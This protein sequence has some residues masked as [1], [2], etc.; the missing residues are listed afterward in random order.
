MERAR[1]RENDME[2][3]MESGRGM[4]FTVW[5]NAVD[6]RAVTQKNS[7]RRLPWRL[8]DLIGICSPLPPAGTSGSPLTKR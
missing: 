7:P 8:L 4:S 6:N 3:E 2:K 5:E 1:T